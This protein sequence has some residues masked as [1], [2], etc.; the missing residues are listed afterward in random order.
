MK[1][2]EL[3]LGKHK[4]KLIISPH[5]TWEGSIGATVTCLLLVN[6]AAKLVQRYT[7]ITNLFSRFYNLN[8]IK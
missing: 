7:Q 1:D 8:S 6:L 3:A 2:K 5:K 4:M